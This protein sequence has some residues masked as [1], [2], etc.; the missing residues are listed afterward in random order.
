MWILTLVSIAVFVGNLTEGRQWCDQCYMNQ[1][2]SLKQ[3]SDNL[4]IVLDNE[5][6]V[7]LKLNQVIL[8]IISI[9]HSSVV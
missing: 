2:L 5:M 6:A 4:I 8:R 3:E 7:I 1:D 9:H